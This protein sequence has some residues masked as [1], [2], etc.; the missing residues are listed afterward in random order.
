MLITPVVPASNFFLVG[1]M[2]CEAAHVATFTVIYRQWSQATTVTHLP[3]VMACQ[4][5]GYKG[6]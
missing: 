1:G 2:S 5:C 3:S 4:T 6:P